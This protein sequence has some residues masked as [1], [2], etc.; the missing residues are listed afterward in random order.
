[1][2]ADITQVKESIAQYAVN[3]KRTVFVR[4]ALQK[5]KLRRNAR[6]P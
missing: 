2:V 1:M 3:F 4:I 6:D 5:S